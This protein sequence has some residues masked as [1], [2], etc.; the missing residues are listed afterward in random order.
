[1]SRNASQNA[2]DIT[3]WDDWADQQQSQE[4]E[5]DV[6]RLTKTDKKKRNNWPFALFKT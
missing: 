1:M 2:Q 5:S 3:C 4:E 6:R